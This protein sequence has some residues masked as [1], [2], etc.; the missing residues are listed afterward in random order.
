M[1][2][3]KILREGDTI[4]MIAP[5]SPSPDKKRIE[6]AV[7]VIEEMGFHVAVGRS[8]YEKWG[9]FAGSD[10][11]RA[12]DINRFFAD[13]EIDGIFCMR[14]GDGAPR[15]LDRLDMKNIAANPKV[16]LGYSDITAL[17]LLFNQSAGFITFHGPMP[18][19]EFIATDFVDYAYDFLRKALMS[20]EPLGEILSPEGAPPLEV[21]SPGEAQGELIGGNLSLICALMGTPYEIDTRR[22]I[23]LI[24]DTDEPNYKIDRM[25]TQ[26]RLAGKLHDAAGIVIGGFT[27]SEPQDP[28]KAFPM[29]ELLKSILL[30]IRKPVLMNLPFG[31][32][33][34][35]VTIPLGARAV[36]DGNN[37]RFFITESGVIDS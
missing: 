23:L 13:P 11:T 17:H 22:R 37:G 20:A 36:L 18:V 33:P 3:V 25:L 16:F 30:P 9:Y 31:H 6:K 27:N 32:G 15:V 5:S 34:Y 12:N 14:G 35:K 8:C 7:K 21:F 26:L 19:T 4:G 2:P 29:N 10:D 1:G 28:N 24:E